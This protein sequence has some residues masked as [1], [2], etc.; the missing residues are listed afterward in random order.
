MSPAEFRIALKGAGLTQRRLSR[1]LD[2]DKA[3][4]L[5]WAQGEVPVPVAVQLLLTAWTR[6]PRLIAGYD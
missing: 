1:I 5:R 2:C 3:T 4:V 6:Y